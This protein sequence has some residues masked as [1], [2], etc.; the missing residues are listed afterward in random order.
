MI[1]GYKKEYS[2]SCVVLGLAVKGTYTF[3]EVQKWLES[4]GQNNA[5]ASS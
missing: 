4:I 2:A 3:N 1:E 5:S